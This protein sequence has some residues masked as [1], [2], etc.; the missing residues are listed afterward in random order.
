[1]KRVPTWISSIIINT[2]IRR[3][4]SKYFHTLWYRKTPNLD[5]GDFSKN[6][7]NIYVEKPQILS[8]INSLGCLNWILIFEWRILEL[9][10]LGYER[11]VRD[12][13]GRKNKPLGVL[14]QNTSSSLGW[15]WGWCDCGKKRFHGNK[16]RQVTLP[17]GIYCSHQTNMPTNLQRHWLISSQS[18]TFFFRPFHQS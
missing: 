18:I 8:E 7:L 16:S 6:M 9:F 3:A 1:M 2:T 11:I 10:H 14:L 4:D 13:I 5:M 12:Y 15:F 17:L